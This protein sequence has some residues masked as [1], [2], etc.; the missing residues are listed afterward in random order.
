MMILLELSNWVR[1][2]IGLVSNKVHVTRI[3]DPIIYN[4]YIIIH[5]TNEIT[6]IKEIFKLR[7]NI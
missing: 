5:E 7:V 4:N 1:V 2:K 6:S 3:V